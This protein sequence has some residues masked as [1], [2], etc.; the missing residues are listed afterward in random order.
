MGKG[1]LAGL[2][3]G[4]A[5]GVLI[6]LMVTGRVQPPSLAQVGEEGLP[7]GAIRPLSDQLRIL[8]GRFEA[9]LNAAQAAARTAA[10]QR[11]QELL[12]RFEEAKRRGSVAQ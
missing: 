5:L 11:Q 9:R 6:T 2:V 10:E 7:G 3:I 8:A 1:L 4:G 12:L